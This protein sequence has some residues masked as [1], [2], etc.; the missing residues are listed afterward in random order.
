LSQS[1]HRYRCG[2]A[3]EQLLLLFTGWRQS[4]QAGAC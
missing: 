4:G 1:L 3:V 2:Q